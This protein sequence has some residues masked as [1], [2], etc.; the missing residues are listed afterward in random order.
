MGTRVRPVRRRD[1]LSLAALRLQL[2]RERGHGARVGFLDSYA[3][4]LLAEWDRHVGWVAED[5]DGR[6]VAF[7][8][9]LRIVELPSLAAATRREWW[10]LQGLFVV[11][12]RRG[13]G[14]GGRLLEA[15]TDA[16]RDAGV[17]HVLANATDAERAAFEAVGFG[18][19][20][21]RLREWRP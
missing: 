5:E 6:P 8:L 10:S 3:D 17:T 4:A 19:P 2:D 14:W 13:E 20:A 18:Q 7:V 1:A 11:P 9:A 21:S 15:L 12:D 16:G